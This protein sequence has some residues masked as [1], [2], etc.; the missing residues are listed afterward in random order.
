ME[1]YYELNDQQWQVMNEH[2]LEIIWI[3]GKEESELR[4][5]IEAVYFI[6]RTLC[7]WRLLPP[8]FRKWSTVYNH[9][10]RWRS[11]KI[12]EFLFQSTIDKKQEDEL[13]IDS[14]IVRA[15]ACSFG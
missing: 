2:L 12:F 6:S 9:F 14:T 4:R 3:G 7:H 15:H 11:R 13:M 1:Y 8:H 10:R 5:F